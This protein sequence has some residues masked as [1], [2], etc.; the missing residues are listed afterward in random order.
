TLPS[1]RADVVLILQDPM[2]NRQ[3]RQI[4]ELATHHRLPVVGAEAPDWAE[5]GGFMAY[6]PSLP[7]LF[8]RPAVNVDK[9]LKGTKPG[10][11]PIERPIKFELVVNLQTAKALGLMVAPSLLLQADRVIQ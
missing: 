3:R 8:R 1:V 7:A 2:L 9:I 10:E 6:G 11:V 4:V 5:A